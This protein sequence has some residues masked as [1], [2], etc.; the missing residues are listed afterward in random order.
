MKNEVNEKKL[1]KEADKSMKLVCFCTRPTDYKVLDNLYHEI[2]AT[3]LLVFG[4]LM[5]SGRAEDITTEGASSSASDLYSHGIKGYY[6]G[7]LVTMIVL[8]AG[9]VGIAANPARDLGPRL[10]HCLL[11]IPGKGSTE[12]HYAWI[13]VL[14]P[15]IGSFI[16]SYTFL[17][18]E[19]L[20]EPI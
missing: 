1:A 14:G 2:M 19:N 13:P 7:L 5:I 16:A 12:W 3:F 4:I 9:G 20:I 10:A 11:P 15:F 6:I 18:F 17:L 8:A